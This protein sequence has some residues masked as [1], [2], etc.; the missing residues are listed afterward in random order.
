MTTTTLQMQGANHAD[1]R[2]EGAP[3]R[4]ETGRNCDTIEQDDYGKWWVR[5]KLQSWQ[6]PDHR[7]IS[8]LVVRESSVASNTP[9]VLP[10]G[11]IKPSEHEF[12]CAKCGKVYSSMHGWKTHYG[13][14]HG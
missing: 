8:V 12:E 3:D 2:A 7:I 4:Y 9:E 14:E 11:L 5:R 13:R 10:T 6:I 1:E